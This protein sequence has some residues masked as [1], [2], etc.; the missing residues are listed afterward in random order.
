MADRERFCRDIGQVW[1]RYNQINNRGRFSYSG[2]A[3]NTPDESLDPPGSGKNKKSIRTIKSMIN[4]LKEILKLCL[5]SVTF[6]QKM[7][8]LDISILDISEMRW[9]NAGAMKISNKTKYYS[10]NNNKRHW[11]G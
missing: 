1:I 5:K 9:P 6:I 3:K 4:I 2:G 11:N 7:N 8:A 10:G